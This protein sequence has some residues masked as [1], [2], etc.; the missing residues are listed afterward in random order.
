MDK[1]SHEVHPYYL[2]H[3]NDG[4]YQFMSCLGIIMVVMFVAAIT[5][6]ILGIPLQ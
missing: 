4:T 3:E 6:N 5:G 1:L 2:R